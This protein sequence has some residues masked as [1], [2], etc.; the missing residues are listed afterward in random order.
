MKKKT[1]HER[2]QLDLVKLTKKYGY[3]R[4]LFIAERDGEFTIC[5]INETLGFVAYTAVTLINSLKR[6]FPAPNIEVKK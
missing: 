3:D 1:K 6:T 4:S 5:G 2:L